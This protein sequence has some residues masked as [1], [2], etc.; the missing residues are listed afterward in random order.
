MFI[1]FCL[2]SDCDLLCC[3]I[4]ATPFTL[5]GNAIVVH[6]SLAQLLY[7]A[8]ELCFFHP[9]NNKMRAMPEVIVNAKDGWYARG[10]VLFQFKSLCNHVALRVDH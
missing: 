3:R 1:Y 6:C 2:Q 5:E 10:N 8:T 4:L 7:I 9:Y